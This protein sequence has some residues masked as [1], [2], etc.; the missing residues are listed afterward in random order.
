MIA[1]P[2]RMLSPRTQNSK[3]FDMVRTSL[4]TSL[5]CETPV[6]VVS[7]LLGHAAVTT[8]LDVYGHLSVEDARRVLE[9]AGWFIDSGVRL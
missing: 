4:T 6:E 9:N 1:E 3:A 7:K 5:R 8:T 2:C